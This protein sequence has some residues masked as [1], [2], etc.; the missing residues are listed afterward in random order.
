MATHG[1]SHME[2][3]RFA[4]ENAIL[5][6]LRA[7]PRPMFQRFV[8]TQISS[9]F[10]PG[11]SPIDLSSANASS[12]PPRVNDDGSGRSLRPISY[13]AVIGESNIHGQNC[14]T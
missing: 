13:V 5:I 6:E 7:V 12:F 8:V 1:L 10:S 9:S 14:D 3:L 2:D 11:S 4:H